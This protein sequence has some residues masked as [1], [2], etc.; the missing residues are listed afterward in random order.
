MTQQLLYGADVV[1]VFH[2]VRREAV[3]K[4]MAACR[5]GD[6]GLETGVPKS[7][8]QHGLVKVMAPTHP[9]LAVGVMA[10]CWENPLPVSLLVGAGIF[11]R[12][13]VGKLDA[14]QP[15]LQVFLMRGLDDGEMAVQGLA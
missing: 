13:S 10:R 6:L 15:L 12:E 8:L 5:L 1:A 4:R 9:R 7:F 3:A 2:E 14:A 11:S